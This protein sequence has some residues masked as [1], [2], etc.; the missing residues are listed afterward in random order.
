[1][2]QLTKLQCQMNPQICPSFPYLQSCP[3]LAYA[4]SFYPL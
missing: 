4:C 1:M 2:L 3:Q